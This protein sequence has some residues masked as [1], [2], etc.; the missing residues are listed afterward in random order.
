MFDINIKSKAIIGVIHI[1][2]LP[3]TP[4]NLHSI[5]EI[6]E[7]AKK[8]A[9]IYIST[10]I[11]SFLIENMHD[12]PYI[13]QKVGP[14]IVASM[15]AV[16]VELRKL[17]SNPIGIQILAGANKEALA[18]AQAASLDFIR[19]EGFV[20]GHLADEGYMNS[21]ASELLRYRKMI[22]AEHILVFTD[23][24]KKHSSHA[25]TADVSLEETV[26]AAQFFMSDGIIITGKTT[27]NAALIEDVLTACQSTLLPVIIGS[28]IT[29]NNIKEY[30]EFADA[31]IIGSHFKEEGK[32]QNEVD[33]KQVSNFMKRVAELRLS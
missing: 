10:G 5:Q 33:Y 13:N 28:G 19:A 18:V 25:I 29:V 17:T 7:Q 3:G 32:W 1:G 9:E 30:W 14:E 12:V 31:F 23:V 20:F 26:K 6:V 2:A 4:K 11:D 8:E 24:K 22:G 15:T 16:S 27:G 21:C